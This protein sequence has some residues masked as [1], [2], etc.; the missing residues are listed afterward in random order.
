MCL[1]GAPREVAVK[2][3]RN[4]RAQAPTVRYDEIQVTIDLRR[5]NEVHAA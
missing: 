2:I 5:P 1:G 3:E 4:I